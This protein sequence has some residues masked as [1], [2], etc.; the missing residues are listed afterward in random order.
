MALAFETCDEP[1]RF[2]ELTAEL[3]RQPAL[4]ID[5]EVADWQTPAP[6]LSLVQVRT[7][8][9]RLHVIDILAPGMLQALNDAFIPGVMASPSVQKWAHCA[10]FERRFLGQD[11][12]QNLF[13]TYELARSVPYHRLPLRSLSLAALA[14]HLLGELVDKTPQR[15]D[16]GM[17]PLHPDQIAYAAADP[18]WCFR[19][20]E[21][22]QDLLVHIDPA[23]ED[24]DA[25][26]VRYLELLGPLAQTG[27]ERKALRGAVQAFLEAAEG[28]RF[29]GFVLHHRIARKTTLAELV[30]LAARVDPGRRYDLTFSVSM[31]LRTAMGEPSCALL[32]PLC[33][34]AS[35]RSFRG[36][37]LQ[38]ERPRA[39]P[40]V[41]KPD[42]AAAADAAFAA[43]D[44]RRRA[45]QSE[46]EELRDR[47]KCWLLWRRLDEWREFSF[48]PPQERW[49][50][51]M[52]DLAG[53]LPAEP[54]ETGLPKRFLLAF[55][56]SALAE[57]SPQ[58]SRIAVL[59]WH[60]PREAP[61]AHDVQLS[62]DWQEA[63]AEEASL[64]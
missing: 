35:G 16:W 1:S 13:C 20:Q 12:V 28:T 5:T 50:A 31:K 6:R 29:G 17:R 44:H 51:D 53:M 41:V 8:A 64:V 27:A 15:S 9:G 62:R 42:D 11:R 55:P 48:S 45:L 56:P 37:R 25:I 58:T 47:I 26:S 30:A 10:R 43:V 18:E 39:A 40:Y 49:Y 33:Q 7:P 21:R 24:P 22:L 34:V 52:R 46:R 23:A 38:G 3:A 14:R 32:R 61:S 19:I 54:Y 57:L 63:A 60:P 36:P 4:W 2:R 59:Q